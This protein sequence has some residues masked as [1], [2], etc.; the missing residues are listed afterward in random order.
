MPNKDKSKG[1]K[2]P[3]VSKKEKDQ[4]EAELVLSLGVEGGGF[5]IYRT[6]LASGGWQFHEEGGSMWILDDDDGGMEEVWSHSTS[7]PVQTIQEML[8]L[9]EDP[10]SWIMF[11]PISIHPEY[12]NIVWGLVQEIVLSLPDEKKRWWSDR[13]RKRWEHLLLRKVELEFR[14]PAKKANPAKT[15]RTTKK[16]KRK[17]PMLDL[18]GNVIAEDAE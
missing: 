2:E 8:T 16:P 18:F 4:K 11:S 15:P 10:D 6:P 14:K 5:S 3:T 17:T 7:K 9:N 1:K 12:R 13:R